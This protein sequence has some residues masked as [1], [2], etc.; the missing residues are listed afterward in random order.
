MGRGRWL[1]WREREMKIVEAEHIF[2]DIPIKCPICGDRLT[3]QVEEWEEAEDGL[4]KVSDCGFKPSCVSEPDIDSDEWEDWSNVHYAT[5]YIDWLPIE[6]P[7]R[8][9][10]NKRYRFDLG[11]ID[12]RDE[13]KEEG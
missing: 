2:D 13:G 4:W 8:E 7:A 6:K 3:W 9:W 11:G 12:G 10:V 5:P 1:D